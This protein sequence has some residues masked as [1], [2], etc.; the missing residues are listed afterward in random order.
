MYSEIK[1]FQKQYSFADIFFWYHK[2]LPGSG[3]CV[4]AT[5]GC[6]V[7]VNIYIFHDKGESGQGQLSYQYLLEFWWKYRYLP[8]SGACV[9]TTVGCVVSVNM[10]RLHNV[11][12]S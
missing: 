6:V 7:S 1:T 5:V 8:G 2:C 4:V 9:V 12:R 3:A 10:H 11:R